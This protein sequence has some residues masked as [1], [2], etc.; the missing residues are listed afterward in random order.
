MGTFLA[1]YWAP[2]G[3][4]GSQITEVTDPLQPWR[5]ATV[6]LFDVGNIDNPSLVIPDAS[7]PTGGN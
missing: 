3:T 7:Q 1:A 6:Q 4:D 5:P 2:D